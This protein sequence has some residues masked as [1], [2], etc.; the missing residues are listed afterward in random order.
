MT[1]E[2]EELVIKGLEVRLA[3]HQA[4]SRAAFIGAFPRAMTAHTGVAVLRDR[5]SWREMSS[6]VH[7]GTLRYLHTAVT[8]QNLAHRTGAA[9]R[10]LFLADLLDVETVAGCGAGL[11]AFTVQHPNWTLGEA[12][13]LLQPATQEYPV[14]VAR[15]S[16]LQQDWTVTVL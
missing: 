5:G 16:V 7:T 10:T 9:I 2:S 6:H 13:A 11:G 1:S 4:L 15:S 3:H 8:V 14:G 12:L